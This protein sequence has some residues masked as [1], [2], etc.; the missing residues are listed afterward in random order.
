M[1][2]TYVHLFETMFKAALQAEALSPVELGWFD[3]AVTPVIDALMADTGA[4]FKAWYSEKF[5][6]AE[7][8]TIVG[9]M[10]DP[11]FQKLMSLQPELMEIGEQIASAP[12]HQAGFMDLGEAIG[13]FVA[14]GAGDEF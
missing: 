6:V 3:R 7:L 9:Y 11:V 2:N 10:K 1:R 13:K 5:D 8:K 12:K 4:A 14:Y